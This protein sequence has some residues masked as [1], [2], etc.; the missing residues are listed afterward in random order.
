MVYK[1]MASTFHSA[2]QYT[3]ITVKH[4]TAPP[5]MASLPLYCNVRQHYNSLF[6]QGT[7]HVDVFEN[8]AIFK[9]HENMQSAV[10]F[11]YL[12]THYFFV[13]VR[14]TVRPR[15]M[16]VEDTPTDDLMRTRGHMLL[17]KTTAVL[18]LSALR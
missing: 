5:K 9:F 2:S 14:I 1:L 11:T 6:G 12:V 17:L 10:I 3:V 15:G 16:N 13:H 18:I 8:L 7:G 4:V